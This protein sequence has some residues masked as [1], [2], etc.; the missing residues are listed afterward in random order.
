[1]FL[2]LDDIDVEDAFGAP[3]AFGQFLNRGVE[4]VTLGKNAQAAPKASRSTSII[5]S[6]NKNATIIYMQAV[7]GKTS[8]ET[9]VSR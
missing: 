7:S 5:N 2:L 9:H 3:T 8:E 6:I 1:M 4:L